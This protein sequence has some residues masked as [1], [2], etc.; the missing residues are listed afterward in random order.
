MQLFRVV[1]PLLGFVLPFFLCL[2]LLKV[3]HRGWESGI[4]DRARVVLS[5]SRT[6]RVRSAQ[7]LGPVSPDMAVPGITLVFRRSTMQETSL[8]ALLAAQQDPASPLYH[9]WLSPETFAARF[10]VAG[11]DIATA[12]S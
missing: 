8:E 2:C 12:E 1:R 9:R 10:G 5:E 6:P 3:P 11:E 4:T 7:D